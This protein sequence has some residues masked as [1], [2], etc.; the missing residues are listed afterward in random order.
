MIA[1]GGATKA[2]SGGAKKKVAKRAP[3]KKVPAKKVPAKKRVTK[4][5]GGGD[6]SDSDSDSDEFDF[7][8]FD[9]FEEMYGGAKKP[10][11]KNP[12]LVFMAKFRKE[13]PNLK[14]TDAAKKGKIPY[15]KLTPAEK[16]KLIK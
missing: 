15:G 3:A 8:E 12:W 2:Y 9:E 5:K 1:L 10:V 16:A 13:H 7:D 6:D 11:R 4:K 14:P